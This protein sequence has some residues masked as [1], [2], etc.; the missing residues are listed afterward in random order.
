MTPPI[1]IFDAVYIPHLRALYYFGS[2]TR[3]TSP[4]T[5][6]VQFRKRNRILSTVQTG[7]QPISPA[8][9]GLLYGDILF[10][11]NGFFYGIFL[12]LD[13]DSVD[14]ITASFSGSS[15]VRRRPVTVEKWPAE[16][17]ALSTR[18]AQDLDKEA[19]DQLTRSSQL[20]I[21][22]Q[23]A[24]VW[25]KSHPADL[26]SV[27]H[28][29]AA[30]IGEALRKSVMK[31]LSV[32][33]LVAGVPSHTGESNVAYSKRFD[34][35]G[36]ALEHNESSRDICLA[37]VAM[38]GETSWSNTNLGHFH[39]GMKQILEAD[40]Y[41]VQAARILER[42]GTRNSHYNN[43]VFTWRSHA[44]SESIEGLYNSSESI[45]VAEL[46]PA[47]ASAKVVHLLGCDDAYFEKYGNMCIYSSLRAG[48]KDAI[49]HVHV[50]NPSSKT[51]ETLE[52]WQSR[53]DVFVRF[54]SESRPH[55]SVSVPYYTSLRFLVAPALMAHYQ[56]PLVI[57][58]IDMVVN[59]PWAETLDAI[60]PADAGYISPSQQ[61][62]IT[63]H[64]G[65][66][67][68]PWDVAAGTMYF[69]N[70]DLGQ[71][72]LNYVATYIRAV[73]SFPKPSEWYLNWG[74][75]Q[76]ALRKGVDIV[77]APHEAQVRN[78]RNVRML[79]GPL[80]H[81]GGKAELAR[82]PAPTPWEDLELEETRDSF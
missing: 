47:P 39:F 1:R 20:R 64:Y 41:Y 11:E 43:G 45:Q 26:A 69:A 67:M 32:P 70:S 14:E 58:D 63:E 77:L 2:T 54:S 21:L 78:L 40:G 3:I 42:S 25:M 51:L 27:D 61:E 62:W 34:L 17:V 74:I 24:L 22:A 48:H 37:D 8:L 12:D 79:R 66:G 23:S 55:E 4:A 72:F 30:Q 36:D 75:D 31:S 46:D 56:R 73:L 29:T 80:M 76:V 53:S 65:Q 18:V 50:C 10:L 28:L 13:A 59:Q 82:E 60:G 57:S 16:R 5:L 19:V 15:L 7:V 81:M 49:V 68:R 44:F 71:R 6:T 9:G 52:A 38:N 35:L 33:L